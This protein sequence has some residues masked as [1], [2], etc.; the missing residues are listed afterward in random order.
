MT[1]EE[2]DYSMPLLLLFILLWI[3]WYKVFNNFWLSGGITMVSFLISIIIY[4]V[5]NL[6]SR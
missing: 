6:G 5:W 4:K 1:Q 3:S 2:E